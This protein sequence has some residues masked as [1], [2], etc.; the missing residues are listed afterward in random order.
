MLMLAF[1]RRMLLLT[2]RL[3][4]VSAISTS[5]SLA[6]LCNGYAHHHMWLAALDRRRDPQHEEARLASEVVLNMMLSAGACVTER[7]GAKQDLPITGLDGNAACTDGPAQVML[8]ELNSLT[9]MG[10]LASSC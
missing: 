1:R 5:C 8:S 7:L 2:A 9:M 6:S 4:S 10:V 3:L